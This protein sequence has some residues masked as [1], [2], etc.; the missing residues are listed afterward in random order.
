ML[1]SVKKSCQT[2]ITH[3]A[4]AA[5]SQDACPIADMLYILVHS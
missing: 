1:G 3:R 5:R 4:G 2:H